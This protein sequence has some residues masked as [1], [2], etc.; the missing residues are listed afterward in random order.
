MN[1]QHRSGLITASVLAM[2][3][4]GIISGAFLGMVFGGLSIK[5]LVLAI[6]CAIVAA[7]LALVV[8]SVVLARDA[9]S[10][11]PL[12]INFLWVVIAS[13]IGG[14]A[15]HELAIDLTE[16]PPLPLV[17]ALSGLLASILIATFA[18]TIF[19]LRDRL[20]LPET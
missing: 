6:L 19:M 12:S 14:L 20:S 17:G 1:V 9:E 16:P 18:I 15:G 4:A 8:R 5:H 2:I 3:L 10:A 7:I 11:L 13:L